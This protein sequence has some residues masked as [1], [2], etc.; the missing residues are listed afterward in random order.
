LHT[1]FFILGILAVWR[2]T[3]LFNQEAGP[4]DLLARFR[5]FLGPGFWGQL[6]DC[7]YCLSIWVSAPFAFLIGI[8]WMERALL[9]PALSGAAILAER[10]TAERSARAIYVEESEEQHVLR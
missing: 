4:G 3:H 1:Y 2:I 10:L 8:G 7:F 9:W 5:R 6:L